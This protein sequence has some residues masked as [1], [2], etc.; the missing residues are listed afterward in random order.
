MSLIK[1]NAQILTQEGELISY[2]QETDDYDIDFYVDKVS[3]IAARRLA[4]YT[5]LKEKLVEFKK[6]LRAEEEQHKLT[7]AK[8][9]RVSHIIESGIAALKGNLPP[10]SNNARKLQF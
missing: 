9:G 1:E 6:C 2:V 5:Q 3:E 10:V 4:I 8:G 7:V